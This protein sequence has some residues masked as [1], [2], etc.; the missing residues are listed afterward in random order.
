MPNFMK[1]NLVGAELFHED[2]QRDRHYATVIV[3]FHS[4]ANAPKQRVQLLCFVT[5]HI[6]VFWVVTK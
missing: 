1:M 5:F 2:R 4:S 6:F 3:A